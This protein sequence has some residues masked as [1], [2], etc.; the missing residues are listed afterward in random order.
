MLTVSELRA[1][2]IRQPLVV[3]AAA[4]VWDV[5]S[6]MSGLPSAQAD[7]QKAAIGSRPSCVLVRVDDRVVGILTERDL[8]RLS[9]QQCPL[10]R[11]VTAVMTRELVTLR[12]SEFTDLF[13]TIH[14]LTKHR[15]RHLP[16]VDEADRLLG[17]ITQESLR[18]LARPID[19]LRLRQVQEVMSRSIVVA[20]SHAS[21]LEL[22]QLMSE[23][24][25]SCVVLV[26]PAHDVIGA[27][28]DPAAKSESDLDGDL[29]GDLAAAS[30]LQPMGGPPVGLVT[31]RDMVQFQALGLP[32]DQT[33]AHLVMSSPV[34]SV[35]PHTSLWEAQQLMADRWIRRLVITNDQGQLLG[36]LSQTRLLQ[37][38]NPLEIYNLATVLETQVS[39]LEQERLALLESRAQELEREVAERTAQLQQQAE[40]EA[41]LREVATQI[42]NALDLHTILETTVQQVQRLLNCARV[43][44]YRFEG[45]C[46][47]VTIA[48]ALADPSNLDQSLLG[49]R[50]QDACLGSAFLDPFQRGQVRVLEDVT[51]APLSDCHRD[52]LLSL[53]MRAQL[54]LPLLVG[55]RL[56]GL[57]VASEC[58]RPRLWQA[59]EIDLL[60]ALGVQVGIALKQATSHAAL[61]AELEERRRAEAALRE[62]EAHQRAL[63]SAL[64]DLLVRLNAEGIFL[65]FVA[66]PEF[67]RVGDLNSWVG[68][69][70]S[71]LL[72]P[73]A[74]RKRMKAIQRALATKTVQFYEQNL[75]THEVLRI[76]EVRV[77]PYRDDEVLVLVRNISDRK[78]VEWQLRDLNQ[79][80]ERQVAKRTTTLQIRE[81]QIRAMV[82]AIP[83]RL[84]RV[85]PRG[86]CLDYSTLTQV[87]HPWG[88]FSAEVAGDPSEAA[89]T[90]TLS[91][92]AD[93]V[94]ADQLEAVLEAVNRAIET[95]QLQVLEQR[96]ILGDRVLDEELRIVGSDAD[97]ALVMVRDVTERKAAEAQLQEREA[98]YRG[99]M[100]GASDAIVVANLQGEILEVN[101]KAEELFGYDRAQLIQMHQSQLHPI[102]CQEEMVQAFQTVI[103]DGSCQL[104][105]GQIQRADEQAIPVEITGSIV[106]V[107]QTQ[108]VQGIFRDIRDRKNAERQLADLSQRLTLALESGAIGCWQW[109]IRANTLVWDERMYSLYGVVPV[110]PGQNQRLPYDIWASSVHPDDR[111]A[112]EQLLYAATRGEARYDTEFRVMLADGTVRH[113]KA[114]GEL[115]CDAQGQPQSMIGVNYDISDRKQAEAALRQSEEKFRRV[116]DSNVV[117]T[118]FTNFEGLIV[119]ANDCFLEMLGYDRL[120][121]QAGRLNWA[122]LTP[123]EHRAQDITAIE[124]LRQHEAIAPWEKAYVHRNGHWVWVLI[125]VAMIAPETGSCVCVVVDISDRKRSEEALR[126]SEEKFRQLAE[127]VDS[128]FWILDLNRTNRIYVSPAYERIW[129]RPSEELYISPDSWAASIHP[130]D[131]DQVLAAIPKQ[132]AGEFDEEYRILRPDGEQR[133]IR[134][135]A[136]PICNAQGE[137]YRLAGIAEDITPLKQAELE[138]E[139]LLQELAAFKLAL[140]AS[141]IVVITDAQGIMT[142]VNDRFL[143]VSGYSREEL[144]GKTHRLVKSG[145]HPASFFKDL[146]DTI[147]A[148]QIWRGEI[149][150]RAKDGRLYWVDS[151]IV[152]FLDRA[153]QPIRFLAVR[154]DITPR[155]RAEIDL[156]NSN[157][158]LS[159]ISQAQT[160]FITAANRL[161]IFEGLLNGLLELTESEYGFIGEVLFRG[162][163]S[164]AI[165]EGFLKIK[166]VPFLQSHSVTNIAWDANTQKFYED[167]YETGMQFTN[168]NTLFGAVI[169]TGKPVIANSPSTD[170]R[171]GGTPPGHPP[172]QAFLGIP[173]YQGN[174]LVGM[175]GIANR[176]GGY[177]S[178]MVGY[179]EPFLVTCST[180]IEGYRVDR[181]RRQAEEQLQC[182]NDELIRAT[183]LKDEFLA[184]MSHELRTPLNAILGMTEGLQEQVFGPINDNQRKAL[185][186]IER[187]GS[188]LLSLI[189][190][191]LDVAKIESGQLELDQAPTPIVPLCQSS[192]T[193]IKQQALKKQIQV[194]TQI[195]SQLPPALLDERRMRQVLINLLNNAVKF[196]PENG[197]V[198]LLVSLEQFAAQESQSPQS[199][200]RFSVIDTGIGIAS[201]QLDRLFR[202]FVQIDSSLNRQYEGTGLGLALVKRIVEL[203]GGRV[204]VTSKLGNGSCFTVDLPYHP[205]RTIAEAGDDQSPANLDSSLVIE[206][207]DGG[208]SPC[209]L[210]AEDQEANVNT[211]VSYLTAKG[212]RMILA[213]NG[214]E[215]IAQVQQ[216]QPDLVLMDVQ[217][218][219]MDGLEAMQLLRQSSEYANLPIVA[220]TALAMEGDRDRCLAAGANEYLTKPVRLRQLVTTIQNLL[221]QFPS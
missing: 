147:L 142:Y 35:S 38:L 159:T 37:A 24:Q 155:K 23:N 221:P 74:T 130:L 141:A 6:L 213:K 146:W 18:Q 99:L 117:G 40:R 75:S 160:E 115:L 112:T 217:M 111:P 182:T 145:H 154:F 166:G 4:T 220:L 87:Q 46:S 153:G 122:E 164:A 116:F 214:A 192:L 195:P 105:N 78:Q 76:E 103:T 209:I 149:C 45:D 60:Q 197:R 202:P 171:S 69:H 7:P 216:S 77:V 188:H 68:R 102:D 56:W 187:T 26:D 151:T 175:I 156:K 180:L 110:E 94:A 162:D 114:Y 42:H 71:E 61:A 62:A 194:E 218:P 98:R 39:Q 118:I 161:T 44:V 88:R 59:T 86:Q 144:I 165:E 32:L 210:L 96:R 136:F 52:L 109:N 183:R 181:Q 132:L 124:H 43:I 67:D 176:P 201:D 73:V 203:H 200:L 207:T 143:A 140:D 34:F 91:Q 29:D 89:E 41:L 33:S 55:D 150:N 17:L 169:M 219:G 113:I 97:A 63:V 92:L 48:E 66:N 191:I 30:S 84:L 58:D 204:G 14:L 54:I 212:Y 49:R 51:T 121:L 47:G 133:W 50:V 107:G 85:T 95:G 190:D 13:S 65:E 9:A 148:G 72:P 137:V 128:V 20:S 57:M 157:F 79:S 28:D 184:N 108:L 125:G 139:R 131:H 211:I 2:I 81:A 101:R 134:D 21:L 16:V 83:D 27:I 126:E 185:G 19:L 178:S 170:P 158:L 189:N 135:R 104:T 198:T 64:P 205:G 106:Q 123:P 36:I 5:V 177:E 152:P 179:L 8:V 100:A 93:W 208:R 22:A 15:I 199:W 138:R 80:L 12:E 193:F 186:T 206:S 167:N 3:D 25:V 90:P 129:G 174:Q 11:P 82:A 163:G 70:V 119:D 53:Q 196:T 173:F 1:A 168:M 127:A 10:D 120:D 215:A 172:L 31:E